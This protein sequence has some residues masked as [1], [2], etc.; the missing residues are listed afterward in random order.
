[1]NK[2]PLS[3]MMILKATISTQAL[4]SLRWMTIVT[5][6]L[7]RFSYGS[8]SNSLPIHICGVKSCFGEA[9]PRGGTFNVEVYQFNKRILWKF[10]GI[11]EEAS[12]TFD[13]N[14]NR[15]ADYFRV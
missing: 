7:I 2:E 11:P 13:F 4:K 8:G 1:M 3:I 5:I 12:R 6:L 10:P 15:S 14:W 9:T